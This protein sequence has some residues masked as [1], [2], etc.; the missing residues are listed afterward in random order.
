M[1]WMWS[2]L[3]WDSTVNPIRMDSIYTEKQGEGSQKNL[4]CSATLAFILRPLFSILSL[5][6]WSIPCFEI[7]LLFTT[8]YTEHKNWKNLH[9]TMLWYRQKNLSVN[10]LGNTSKKLS[11]FSTVRNIYLFRSFLATCSYYFASSYLNNHEF[12]SDLLFHFIQLSKY[13]TP[14]TQHFLGILLCYASQ[15]VTALL[16]RNVVTKQLCE[17][18][19]RFSSLPLI[20]L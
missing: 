13:F 18:L 17:L 15:W 10:S 12:I 19:F 5:I 9:R 7:P 20:S 6:Q 14:F 8:G 2:I 1:C 4:C 11:P 3:G 16:L